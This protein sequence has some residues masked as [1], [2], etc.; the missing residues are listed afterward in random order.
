MASDAGAEVGELMR[1]TGMS[2]PTVYR[3][4]H[5]HVRA[6]RVIQ[7]SRGRWRAQMTEEPPRD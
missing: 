2:R 1:V 5:E 3:H 7:V 6:G 4:L